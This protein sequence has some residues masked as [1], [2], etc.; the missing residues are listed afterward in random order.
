MN[1]TSWGEIEALILAAARR[2]P[3]ERV[4]LVERCSDDRL[5]TSLASLVTHTASV[6]RTSGAPSISLQA[7]ER[8]GPYVVVHRLGRGG[9]GEVFL[10]RDSRLHR[11]VALKYLL[12][13]D[14]AAQELQ[15][16]IVREARL[17]AS[18]S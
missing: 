2:P 1:E 6:P 8:V 9:M 14:Q 3:A 10:A 4:E 16:R 12:P 5:R 17:A 18:I 11:L 13:S 15:D 7:G